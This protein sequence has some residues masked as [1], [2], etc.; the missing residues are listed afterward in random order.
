MELDGE[1]LLRRVL[2]GGDGV[3]GLAD[4]LE[5]GRQLDGFV[6]M[7]HPHRQRPAQALEQRSVVAQQFHLGVTV[8]ALVSGAHLAA[9]LVHHELQA[10]TDA[11]HRHAEMQDSLVRR[12]RIGVIDRRRPARQHDAGGMI[13]LDFIEWSV[14]R[15][16]DGEDVQFADA[17]RD[18]LRILRAKVEDDDR[19]G[20]H[21]LLCQRTRAV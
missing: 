3:R 21:Y 8:L 19:L 5:A 17:A 2:N 9:Q 1:I 4:Q 16:D 14:A 11:Q 6:A 15:Q 13:A 18:E 20:F 12:R 10:V 7:R